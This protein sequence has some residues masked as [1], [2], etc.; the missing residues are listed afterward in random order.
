MYK[1]SEK[2]A[3]FRVNSYDPE[4]P[5]Y[6]EDL[7][8]CTELDF[9]QIECLDP[10]ELNYYFGSIVNM[11]NTYYFD[12]NLYHIESEIFIDYGL[13]ENFLAFWSPWSFFGTQNSCLNPELPTYLPQCC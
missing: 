2:Q 12:T 5:C 4:D 7:P 3:T 10:T 11:Y 9:E 1:Y 8:E 6:T 13:C